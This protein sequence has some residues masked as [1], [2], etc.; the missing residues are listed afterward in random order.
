MG[1]LPIRSSASSKVIHR[2]KRALCR[3]T[4]PLFEYGLENG[5]PLPPEDFDAIE[6]E[7]EWTVVFNDNTDNDVEL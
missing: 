2:R 7:L 1:H 5:G 6:G 4:H 3:R